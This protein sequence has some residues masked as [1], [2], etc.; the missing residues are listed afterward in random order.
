[1]IQ[2]LIQWIVSFLYVLIISIINR[3]S[4]SFLYNLSLTE[5][6]ELTKLLCMRSV[7]MRIIRKNKRTTRFIFHLQIVRIKRNIFL[8]HHYPSFCPFNICSWQS[9]LLIFDIYDCYIRNVCWHLMYHKAYIVNLYFITNF[10]LK[11]V[12]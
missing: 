4:L 11:V 7:S 12:R 5:F 9:K 1:M 2:Y 8:E 6:M 10:W 3:Y